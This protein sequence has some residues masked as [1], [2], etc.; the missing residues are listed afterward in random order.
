MDAMDA[1]CDDNTVESCREWIQ[2][3]RRYFPHCI[4]RKDIRCDMGENICFERQE[5]LDAQI[6]VLA[7]VVHSSAQEVFPM[8]YLNILICTMLIYSFLY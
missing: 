3:S 4:A 7:I 1:A 2:H 5:C 6:E 8:F